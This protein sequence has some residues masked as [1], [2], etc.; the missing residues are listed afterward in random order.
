MPPA[1]G[2]IVR[3]GGAYQSTALATPQRFDS[4]TATGECFTGVVAD[5]IRINEL[6]LRCRRGVPSSSFIELITLETQY[7]FSERM[8]LRLYDR[9]GTLRGDISGVVAN[10][11]DQVVPQSATVL[12]AASEFALSGPSPDASLRVT[13]D[14]LAGR[15]VLYLPRVDGS[16]QVLSDV[17][18]GSAG[19]GLPPGGSL[20]RLGEGDYSVVFPAT[21]KNLAGSI[22]APGGCYGPSP[23][24]SVHFDELATRCG[25]GAAA[26]FV[27]LMFDAPHTLVGEMGLE[28]RNAAGTVISDIRTIYGDRVGQSVV[29]GQRL[30]LGSAGLV[31]NTGRI[32][33]A[34]IPL[35][36]DPIGGTLTL[37][38]TISAAPDVRAVYASF[39]YGVPDSP[40][41][42]P[43]SSLVRSSTGSYVVL[44][45]P[46][47]TDLSGSQPFARCWAPVDS[48]VRI[49]ELALACFGGDADTRFVELRALD[50]M[51]Q[52]DPGLGV[53]LLDG[54][55]VMLEELSVVTAATLGRPWLESG[56]MLLAPA[57]FL[58]ATGVAPD[59]QLSIG[60]S[61]VSGEVQLFWRDDAHT[62]EVVLDSWRYGMTGTT[63]LP[64]P[65]GAIVRQADGSRASTTVQSPRRLD[66]TEATGDCFAFRSPLGIQVQTVL[67]QCLDRSTAAQ[68]VELRSTSRR[69]LDPS[70]GLEVRGA[71]GAV[72]ADLPGVFSA[73]AWQPFATGESFLLAPGSAQAFAG[74]APDANLSVLLDTLGGWLRLY[75]QPAGQPRVQLDEFAY[76]AAVA[77]AP[78]LAPGV[79]LSRIAS[80]SVAPSFEVARSYPMLTWSLSD[81]R[82]RGS[83]ASVRVSE[84]SLGCSYDPVDGTGQFIELRNDGLSLPSMQGYFLRVSVPAGSKDYPLFVGRESAPFPG[85][86]TWLVTGPRF[87]QLNGLAGDEAP[88]TQVPNNW[89]GVELYRQGG[90]GQAPTLVDAMGINTVVSGFDYPIVPYGRSLERKPDGVA[91]IPMLTN[92][93]NSAGQTLDGVT[94]CLG[95]SPLSS[96]IPIAAFSPGCASGGPS[97]AYI[98]FLPNGTASANTYGALRLRIRNHT[99][100][101]TYDLGNLFNQRSAGTYLMGAEGFAQAAQTSANGERPFTLDALGGEIMVYEPSLAGPELVH[102]RHFYGPIAAGAGVRR[103]GVALTPQGFEPTAFAMPSA[104]SCYGDISAIGAYFQGA[105]ADCGD[106]DPTTRYL[107]VA[108]PTEEHCHSDW[109]V[110]CT[111]SVYPP[112]WGKLRTLDR[113]GALLDSVRLRRAAEPAGIWTAAGPL[114]LPLYG[115]GGL[116]AML[117]IE[118]EPV[119]TMDPQGGTLQ[120]IMVDPA[121]NDVAVVRQTPYGAAVGTARTSPAWVG[122]WPAGGATPAQRPYKIENCTPCGVHG[123]ALVGFLNEAYPL[124]VPSTAVQYD[125]ML[126]WAGPDGSIMQRRFFVDGPGGASGFLL[127]GHDGRQFMANTSTRFTVG[128]IPTGAAITLRARLAIT[129]KVALRL[130]PPL[131]ILPVMRLRVYADGTSST[132][133]DRFYP[134]RTNPG[135][136][137]VEIRDTISV[138]MPVTTGVPF[139]LTTGLA[140][141]QV[142]GRG[143]NHIEINTQWI[144]DALPAGA[145]VTSCHGF[146]GG[147]V[148]T[149]LALSQVEAFEDRVELSW[150]GGGAGESV[151]LERREESAEWQG[152]AEL[153]AD[154]TGQ[155]HFSDESVRPGHSYGY[156]L[157]AGDGHATPE[158]KVAVPV[159]SQLTLALAG[160]QPVRGD[161]VFAITRPANTQ[162][163][164]ELFDVAGRLVATRTLP[165]V[166]PNKERV[167]LTPGSSRAGIFLARLS[168]GPE[169]RV[170]RVVLVP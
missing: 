6:G 127:E 143:I 51:A 4:K 40:A 68:F 170:L 164:L 144:F 33:D 47:P 35:E 38:E 163:R 122:S 77:G 111:Y 83:L 20:Q 43:G 156:R 75:F 80:G 104:W 37:Y 113:A 107:Q 110:Y 15:L 112:N 66:G 117:G 160:S 167:T 52:V 128:G 94:S 48:A 44:S 54:A 116:A 121:G 55:G 91:T 16:E 162:A 166:S 45:H 123:V 8:G 124:Y 32:P 46:T 1:G 100:A 118:V 23:S 161:I 136:T 22:A 50:P 3:A 29:A 60:P 105:G 70:V 96:M 36:L 114:R 93:R 11:A 165:A 87:Q 7:T 147:P 31:A 21:P 155:L 2:S 34:T 63:P 41:P 141:G 81:C 131:P 130:V 135:D 84:I 102:G 145:E 99:G 12:V 53:R 57:G 18:Y 76:G 24:A 154:G 19:S 98:S 58:N 169:H 71:D 153:R 5:G 109:G 88:L 13:P 27:E 133:T 129:G 148:P 67:L 150:Q 74:R 106:G 62:F 132:I 42:A 97:S 56:R 59:A 65:G 125:T 85:G 78:A 25:A 168:S 17:S 139:R 158:T 79:A 89:I 9:F 157:R 73:R 92:P 49:S 86:G 26:S 95:R 39:A 28:I 134:S 115:K 138:L 103:L 90:T 82:A 120:L 137:L 101:L 14:T 152:L 108:T 30:L 126:T 119:P 10:H 146:G 140:S 149:L 61:P 72:L 69:A 64:S 142:G 159:A 151:V